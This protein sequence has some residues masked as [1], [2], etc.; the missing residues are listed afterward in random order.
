MGLSINVVTWHFTKPLPVSLTLLR[1]VATIND[2]ELRTYYGSTSTS[3][4]VWLV[5]KHSIWGTYLEDAPRG[6]LLTKYY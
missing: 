5:Y 3:G 4:H 2:T 6:V 1:Y